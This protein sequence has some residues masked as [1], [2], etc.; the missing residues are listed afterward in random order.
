M[1]SGER[2]QGTVL[3]RGQEGYDE[4]RRAAVWNELRPDR[5]PESIVRAASERDV[6]EA[7]ALARS[8]G[9]RLTVRAGGHN[10]CG[11]SLRDGGML[12]DLSALQDTAIDAGS[13]TDAGSATAKVQPGVIGSELALELDRRGL[14]FPAGHCPTVALGGYLLSGG[15]GWNGT[16]LGPACASVLGVEAVTADGRTVTCDPEHHPDLFWAARGAGPG[17]FAVVTSF[18]LK[19]GPRPAAVTTTAYTFPLAELVSV[20]RWTTEAARE[21]PPHVELS[22]TL[23]TAGQDLAAGS[24]RPKA[25]VV[26]GTAFAGSAREAAEALAPLGDCPFADRALGRRREEPTPLATLYATAG[27]LWPPGHRY[28]V[29]TLWTDADHETLLTRLA[30]VFVRA[31]SEKSLVLVP[32]APVGRAARLWAD[33]AFS[34]L[35]TNYVAPFAI[36]EDPA[37][38]AANVRWLRETMAAVEPLG[39]GH[40]IAEADL[41][42]DPSRARRSYAPRD[43]ARLERL[44]AEYDPRGLFHPY[45]TP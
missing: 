16:A 7:L 18:R 12:L 19:L 21:L 40:Y 34:A 4:A 42:A 13:V 37:D 39:T 25:V 28:A 14:A 27:T 38:D 3:Q 45:L 44:R 11:S 10:W 23:A 36:W 2:I 30:E 9:L 20:T 26:T 22:L 15:L 35:G 24:P 29:D 6:P 32:F 8:S 17:F 1:E 41:T 31:P 43:W 5:Q 33:T